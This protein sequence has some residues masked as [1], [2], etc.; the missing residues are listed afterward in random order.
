MCWRST[1]RVQS[2]ESRKASIAVV[3][4]ISGLIAVEHSGRELVSSASEARRY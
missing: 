4:R 2:L 1:I 3:G